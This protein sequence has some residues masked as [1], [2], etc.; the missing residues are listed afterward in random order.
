MSALKSS[1]LGKKFVLQTDVGRHPLPQ[2]MRRTSKHRIDHNHGLW[3]FFD[4]DRSALMTPEALSKHGRAW[5]VAELRKKDFD[6]LWRLYWTCI[7]EVNRINTYE[8]ERSRLKI[9]FGEHEARLR[10]E[11]AQKTQKAIKHALTERWYQFESARELAMGDPEINLY[12]NHENG[13][14][15]YLPSQGDVFE[16]IED[17]SARKEAVRTS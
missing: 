3:G 10:L 9:H 6:D 14:P 17:A 7:R 12:A 2:P 15:A 16:S 4:Q 1:G 8:M 13:E 11:E 5:T